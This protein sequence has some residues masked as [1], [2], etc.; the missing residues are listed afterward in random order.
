MAQA[1]QEKDAL[2][3]RD[4]ASQARIRELENKVASLARAGTPD[5]GA[6]VATAPAPGSSS[7]DETPGS[8]VDAGAAGAGVPAS[9]SVPVTVE[10]YLVRIQ[11]CCSQALG[12]HSLLQEVSYSLSL[13]VWGG[14]PLPLSLS[15]ARF[16]EP[17]NQPSLPVTYRTLSC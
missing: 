8:A 10:N 13:W 14:V 3:A 16:V 5:A 11:G 6:A 2:E 15:Y 9:D 12:G 17:L 4:K 7:M 1:K